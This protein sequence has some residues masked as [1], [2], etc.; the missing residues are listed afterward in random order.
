M[1]ARGDVIYFLTMSTGFSDKDIQLAGFFVR[2]KPFFRRV[3][4]MTV[5]VIEVL[6]ILFG[7]YYWGMWYGASRTNELAS[8]RGFYE[9]NVTFVQAHRQA[10]DARPLDIVA[11]KVL[12]GVLQSK[13]YVAIVGNPNERWAARVSYRFAGTTQTEMKSGLVLPGERAVLGIFGSDVQMSSARFVFEDIQWERIDAHQVAD[14]LGFK[15]ER[16]KVLIEGSQYLTANEEVNTDRVQFVLRNDSVFDYFSIVVS[17]VLY[18]NDDIV[19]VEQVEVSPFMRL[20][21]Q[22]VEIHTK[23]RGIRPTRMEFMT[24]LNIFDEKSYIR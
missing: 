7:L 12:D 18:F 5:I 4:I 10:I 1:V 6:V 23:A 3:A 11:V 16:E 17:V 14:V 20:S 15:N 9:E 2:T 19:G 22:D 8:L 13:D 24:H 21:E